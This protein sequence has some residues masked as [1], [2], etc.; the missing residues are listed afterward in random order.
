[1]IKTCARF[2][3]GQEGGEEVL[4]PEIV[5]LLIQARKPGTVYSHALV[6]RR[7]KAYAAARRAP[8]LPA[9]PLMRKISS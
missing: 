7:W 8:A 5:Q 1:M 2:M 6:F 9:N 4:S 3:L